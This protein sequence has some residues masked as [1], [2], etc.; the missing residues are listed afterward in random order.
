MSV[1]FQAK[2]LPAP[3]HEDHGSY[4][5]QPTEMDQWRSQ[6]A[7]SAIAAVYYSWLLYVPTL[8]NIQVGIT[9]SWDIIRSYYF[10]G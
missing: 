7:I 8:I 3:L 9:G 4:A 1:S 2:T 10:Q 6:C 5:L